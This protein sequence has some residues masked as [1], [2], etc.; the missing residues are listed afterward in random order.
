MTSRSKEGKELLKVN[1]ISKSSVITSRVSLGPLFRR[2]ACRSHQ[3]YFII[4]LRRNSWC[5]FSLKMLFVIQ[6]F[7]PSMPSVKLLLFYY[8]TILIE[9]SRSMYTSNSDG[10]IRRPR[11]SWEREVAAN[12]EK[13]LLSQLLK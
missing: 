7:T 1:C 12:A 9:A 10:L 6:L 8:R 2:L 3:A 11:W 13:K 5:L 4:D